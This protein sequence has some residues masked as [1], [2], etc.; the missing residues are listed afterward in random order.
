MKKLGGFKL[1]R[2]LAGKGAFAEVQLEIAPSR[3]FSITFDGCDC[4]EWSADGRPV[5]AAAV[6]FGIRFSVE[7]LGFLHALP[8][9]QSV[10]VTRIYTMTV[11]S[12]EAIVAYTASKAYFSAIGRADEPMILDMQTR[13]VT[14]P[15]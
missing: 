2:Q 6:E 13:S 15:S 7:K 4:T 14:M 9:H 12:T 1:A 11:D 8:V 5:Y 3:A 10:R